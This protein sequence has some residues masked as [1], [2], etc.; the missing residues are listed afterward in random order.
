MNEQITN[1]LYNPKWAP[2]MLEAYAK[3][4][5]EEERNGPLAMVLDPEKGWMP[6]KLEKV[7]EEETRL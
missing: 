3:T 2:V 4:L 7:Q 5:S 1:P 6:L